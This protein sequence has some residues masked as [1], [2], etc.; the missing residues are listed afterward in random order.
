MF[1]LDIFELDGHPD[2]PSR[3]WTWI[4][5]TSVDKHDAKTTK[6]SVAVQREAPIAWPPPLI[7]S[8]AKLEQS[9]RMFLNRTDEEKVTRERTAFPV[10]FPDAS[11][12][13]L[14]YSIIANL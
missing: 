12:G 8:P 3:T 11:A 10:A 4:Q 5:V 13:P 1:S 6:I 9:Q 14:P 2:S 7:R